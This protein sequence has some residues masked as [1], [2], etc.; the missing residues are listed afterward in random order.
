LERV[1]V[2]ITG[3]SGAVYGKRLVEVLVANSFGVELIFSEI[4]KKVFEFETGI[5]YADFASSLPQDLVNLYEPDDLFAPPSSGSHPVR[6]MVIAPCSAGTLGHIAGGATVNLIHRAADVNLK[7]GR[8]LV[9][10]FRETP[11]NRIH[12]ENILKVID[13]GA[14]VLP[15]SPAFYGRPKEVK[16]LVDFVVE[17]ALRALLKREFGL[18][19]NWNSP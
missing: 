11:L 19:K 6:G 13:A 2:G 1:V 12:A 10:V 14:T 3:A 7:E 8:P 4:G 15:A 16:E 9:L 18:V 17:R 5:N